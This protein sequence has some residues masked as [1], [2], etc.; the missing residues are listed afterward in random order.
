MSRLSEIESCNMLRA[1]DDSNNKG[2]QILLGAVFGLAGI[3]IISKIFGFAEKVII[4]HFFGTGQV[5]DVY[6]VSMGFVLSIVFLIKELIHPSL[7]P[8]F[9][10]SLDSGGD[11]S[12]VLFRRVF[13]YSACLLGSIAIFMAV[14]PGVVADIFVP[15]FSDEKK[16]LTAWL[17]RLLAPATIVWGLSMVT[18]TALNGRKFFIRA[19]WPEAMMK[20]FIA[21][22][23]LLIVPMAGVCGVAIVVSAGVLWLLGVQLFFLPESRCL[24]RADFGGKV[25]EVGQVLALMGPIAIGVVSSHVSGVVDNMLGS[26]LPD[27]GLAYLGYSKKLIDA[28][29]LAG[30]VALVTVVYSQLCHLGGEEKKRFFAEVFGKSL[31]LI[32]YFALPVSL[33]LVVLRVDIISLLF[34]RGNFHT[35]STMATAETFM[36]YAFGLMTFSLESLVVCS[37]FALKDTKTPVVIGIVAVVVDI[38]L[39][40]SFLSTLGHLAIAMALVVS[41]SIKVGVL[42]WVMRRRLGGFWDGGALRFCLKAVVAAI[43]AGFVG[44]AVGNWFVFGSLILKVGVISAVFSSTFVIACQLLKISELKEIV[45]LMLKKKC[46]Q[47]DCEQKKDEYNN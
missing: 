3:S 35:E 5:A 9:S 23:L 41:K 2:R 4:A 10:R 17:I 46:E 13:F 21:A 40:W 19:A 34:E 12:G 27:G 7:L 8:I 11:V 22:G 6:F 18:M 36:F 15:G 43:A 33:L 1:S 14:W 44:W 30:P 29:L 24:L 45:F 25:N 38:L 42:L 16:K 37:F 20:F 47:I 31:R 26:T 28:I 39:A 32:V